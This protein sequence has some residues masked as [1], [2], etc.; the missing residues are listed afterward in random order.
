MS[1]ITTTMHCGSNICLAQEASAIITLHH[2]VPLTAESRVCSVAETI[3]MS[4]DSFQQGWV[5]VMLQPVVWEMRRF[6]QDS[7]AL[8]VPSTQISLLL[9]PVYYLNANHRDSA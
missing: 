2:K 8:K 4:V 1:V 5:G 3:H 6:S 7:V 9:I